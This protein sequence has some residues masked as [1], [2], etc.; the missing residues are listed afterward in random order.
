MLV[1]SQI[2]IDYKR[3]KKPK[4]LIFDVVIAEVILT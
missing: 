4:L 2:I 3:Y 1:N